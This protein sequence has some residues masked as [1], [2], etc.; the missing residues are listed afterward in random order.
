[1]KALRLILYYYST[2]H[3]AAILIIAYVSHLN[4]FLGLPLFFTFYIFFLSALCYPQPLT[5]SLDIRYLVKNK[6]AEL[7]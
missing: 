5:F 2:T 4:Y 6:N 1:M 3:F 7:L